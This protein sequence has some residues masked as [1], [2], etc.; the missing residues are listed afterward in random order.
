MTFRCSSAFLHFLTSVAWGSVYEG[1]C[2]GTQR[3]QFER[4][5]EQYANC[6]LQDK[7][8]WNLGEFPAARQEVNYYKQ[9]EDVCKQC[10]RCAWVSASF[11]MRDCSW[12]SRCRPRTLRHVPSGFL[13]WQV[14]NESDLPLFF[15]ARRT[16]DVQRRSARA[17][18]ADRP[19]KRPA[20]LHNLARRHNAWK[21]HIL[22]EAYHR[23]FSPRRQAVADV[24]E[25]GVFEGHS[26]M[27]WADY[28]RAAHVLGVDHFTGVQGTGSR[29]GPINP[30]E[31]VL[32]GIRRWDADPGNGPGR[33]ALHTA[34][35]ANASS[36]Q[37]LVSSL[38]SRRFDVIIDDGS[39]KP[40]D[41]LNSFFLLF[42]LVRPGGVYVIEDIGSSWNHAYGHLRPNQPSDDQL[43]RTA[44]GLVRR[45]LERG[46][47]PAARGGTALPEWPGTVLDVPTREYL[48]RCI[49]CV[50]FE[51]GQD[52]ATCLI[53]KRPSCDASGNHG[54]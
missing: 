1:Y 43:E 12:F 38:G 52:G 46:E 2:S 8:S 36:L 17:C 25:I 32:A 40:L 53:R 45:W 42:A 21:T 50:R 7:G 30:I 35:Q 18:P 24:M 6:K 37:R 13:T 14:K 28:F 44:L 16:L 10:E 39:H 27:M 49:D 15:P 47:L 9:C 3:S 19:P 31:K 20:Q 54:A 34:D 48:T 33:I 22:T 26:L 5:D 51:A 29:Q 41:Q 23:Y 11:T 4:V